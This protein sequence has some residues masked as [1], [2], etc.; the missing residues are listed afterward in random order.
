MYNCE[1]LAPVVMIARGPPFHFSQEQSAG[2]KCRIGKCEKS[3]RSETS[4]L[5]V[6]G[7]DL[8]EWMGV[9]DLSISGL[10][11]IDSRR[12]FDIALG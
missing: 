2:A 7:L 5:G 11:G 3:P 10:R 12:C 9:V 1:Y 8:D 6:C 4:I